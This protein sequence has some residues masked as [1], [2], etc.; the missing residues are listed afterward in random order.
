MKF[1]AW[2][3]TIFLAAALFSATDA[4]SRLQA[5]EK[6]RQMHRDS[7]FRTVQ[8]R[9]IGPYFCSGRLIDIEGYATS[10]YMFY[11][12]AASGGVWKTVNNGNTWQP[13]FDN[14]STST[15]GDIAVYEKDKNLIWVGSGEANS[16][17]SSYAGTGVFKSTDGGKSWSH[18]GLADTQHIARV[19]IDPA[20][21]QVV[22]VAAL[23]HLYTDNEERGVYKTTDG[24]K[25]WNKVLYISP[26]TGVVDLVMHPSNRSILY[27]AAWQK[28]RKA[29]NLEEGGPESAI[30]KSTDGGATWKKLEGGFPQGQG[31]GRI[32][33]A[34]SPSRPETLYA[35][36]DNQQPR[37][38]EKK[39]Q[40]AGGGLTI[41]KVA[42]MTPAEFLKLGKE[43]VEKFLRENRVPERYTADM[44]IAMVQG[45]KVSP[46]MIAKM[47]MDANAR[48]FRTNIKGAE[49]YRS[50]DGGATWRKT[51]D[52]YI[53]NLIFTYGYYFGQVRVSPENEN[54]VY[55]LGVPVLM[56]GDGGKTFASISEQGGIYGIDGVHADSHALWIDPQNPE[57]LLLGNDGGLNISYDRGKNWVKVNNQPLAQCYTVAYD[58]EKP[59]NVYTGLQDN[60]VNKGSSVFVFDDHD[61]PWKML[62]GGDGAFVAP[63]PGNPAVVYAEF[64]FGSMFRLDLKNE[65]NTKSIQPKSP[66]SAQPYRFNWLTP[67]MI[68]RHNPYTILAGANKVLK[69]VDRGDHWLEISPDLTERKNTDGDVPFATITAIDESPFTPEL[70]YAGTDD[71]NVWGSR[72]SGAEWQKITAGLP[73]KWVTRVVTSAFKKE[74]VYLTMTGYR[75][76][77]S[78]AYVFVSEDAGKT[79]TSLKNNL[80]D[81]SLNVIREDPTNENILYLGGDMSIYVSLDRGKAWHSL[82]GNL[83][84]N[85]VY[86]LAVHPRDHEL[87]IGTHGRGVFILPLGLVRRLTPEVMQQPLVAFDAAPVEKDREQE[88]GP[89]K[90][91]VPV[92]VRDGGTLEVMIV[93][94]AAG[95]VLRTWK[96]E[97]PKGLGQVVWDLKL[98]DTDTKTV[99]KGEYTLVLKSAKAAIKTVIKVK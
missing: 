2:I 40:K 97:C 70:L 82:R 1:V 27:A 60:G 96:V 33:L 9:E 85:A 92:Y 54:I 73:G 3:V 64:Q 8:W 72:N 41:E 48:L 23:G 79:W 53:D 30:Y 29:W 32:G 6:H 81:E 90:A 37:P 78:A 44:V 12:A 74:R 36:L 47:M 57:R 56:S 63:E 31:V 13:V 43:Q 39:E 75:E 34:I 84:L 20:D 4:Q 61:R 46:A 28:D 62:L 17:R 25:T 5:Y 94:G 67:F 18:M 15:V 91:V 86:D 93:Q 19:L 45:G 99:D 59:Y 98:R 24:G 11:V 22:Y 42:A 52:K 77:D 10:P 83:P 87:I 69:S 14:E 88:E 16:S 55:L 76:D 66:D 58:M 65:N 51:H 80:P 35:F 38:E 89:Q 26:K 21:P 71:G 68:S 49:L 95:K 50:D 7:V